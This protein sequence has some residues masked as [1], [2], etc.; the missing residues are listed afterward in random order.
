MELKVI[1]SLTEEHFAGTRPANGP[2]LI[3]RTVREI[4]SPNLQ[5]DQMSELFD[6]QTIHPG[7]T[8]SLPPY[9]NWFEPQ[10]P[11]GSDVRTSCLRVDGPAP[12]AGWSVS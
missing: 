6:R 8:D 7:S 1:S 4:G 2:D 11:I 12:G 9:R 3:G 10:S 5:K